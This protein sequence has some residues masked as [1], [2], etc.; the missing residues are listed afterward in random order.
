MCGF[1]RYLYYEI[2]VS[3]RTSSQV[4]MRDKL[5][6]P[7]RTVSFVFWTAGWSFT[8]DMACDAALWLL[9]GN[10]VRVVDK[11]CDVWR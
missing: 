11:T 8:A 2:T 7:F 5:T 1:V 10:V 6:S 9:E 3:V 4:E